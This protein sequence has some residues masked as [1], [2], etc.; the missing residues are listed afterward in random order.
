MLYFGC[1]YKN[2]DYIY[3]EELVE[4]EKEQVL[5]QL[6]VAFSRDQEQKVRRQEG[7]GP[8]PAH[9]HR[10]SRECLRNSVFLSQVYVQHLLKSNKEHIWKLINSENAHIYI[11]G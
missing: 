9:T 1:R 6:N 8:A 2:E 5:T 7:V 10:K 3:Q 11:C 4:A